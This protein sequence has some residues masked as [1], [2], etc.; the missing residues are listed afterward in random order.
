VWGKG[1]RRREPIEVNGSVAEVLKLI[2][3][4]AAAR[5]IAL[6]VELASD[7]GP[8]LGDRVQIQ[9]VVLNLL[10]NAFDAVQDCNGLDRQGRLRTSAQDS[11]AVV[12]VS[13][14]GSGLPDEALPLIFE[15][16]FT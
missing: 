13:D 6:E 7:L 4:S 8:V 9:Q 11:A 12:E 1:G 2:Q 5:Q 15:T 10:L 3:N 14:P 16:L